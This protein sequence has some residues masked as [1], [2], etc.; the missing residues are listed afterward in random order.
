MPLTTQSSIG[1]LM[2]DEQARA[3][4]D[5]HLPGITSHPQIAMA[6]SMTLS[7]I[8]PFS[9]GQLTEEKIAEFG[10]ALEAL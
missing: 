1:E 2:D 6:R 9:N 3:L 8:I 10:K 7:A 5:E 4:L